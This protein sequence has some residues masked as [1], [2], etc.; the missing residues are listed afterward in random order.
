[1]GK[2]G[3]LGTEITITCRTLRFI[4]TGITNAGLR[5]L[6]GPLDIPYNQDVRDW[7]PMLL[8]MTKGC[9]YQ[10]GVHIPG[11]TRADAKFLIAVIC[12]CCLADFGAFCRS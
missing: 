8:D 4:Y 12:L 10:L 6:T 11:T 9:H 2:A 5:L 7:P 3:I 1:M